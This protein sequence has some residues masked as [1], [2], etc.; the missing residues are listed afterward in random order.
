MAETMSSI[1]EASGSTSQTLLGRVKAKD[2]DAWQR[3]A[4]I[5]APLVYFWARRGGLQE[6]DAQDVV[7]DV[8][9]AVHSKIEDFQRD[10][11]ASRFRGWLWAI[12]R[13]RVR[14]FY[15]QRQTQIVASG[16]SSAAAALAEIPELWQREEEASSRDERQLVIRQ[17]LAA[18]KQDFA[19][20][21]WQ[22]FW[23]T[24]VGNEA[25]AAVA[26]DLQLTATA[27]RQAKYR[28]LCRLREELAGF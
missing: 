3:F 27:V 25:A 19:E 28:V 21:T 9:R 6:S 16:G 5:Y 23:R 22:A 1:F 2:P 24:A 15:R 8:F 14:L 12:T 7:Q 4:A 17:A 26:A 11:Q 13:N 10:G 18:V 20:V